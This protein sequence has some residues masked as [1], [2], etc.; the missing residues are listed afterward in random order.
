MSERARRRAFLAVAAVLGGAALVIAAIDGAPIARPT[1]PGPVGR[2]SALIADPRSRASARVRPRDRRRMRGGGNASARRQA[3]R[4]LRAFLRYQ[5]RGADGRVHALLASSAE[6]GVRDYLTGAPPRGAAAAGRPRVASL[7]LYRLRRGELKASALLDYGGERSLFEFL[8][9][10]R[11][12]D[13]R[14]SELYP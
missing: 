14:V 12:P 7:R 6:A 11:G 13:W 4:F 5:E 10:R 2:T 8:L 9:R 3:R 1:K